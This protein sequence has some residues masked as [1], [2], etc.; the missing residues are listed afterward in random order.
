[1]S[2]VGGIE[3]ARMDLIGNSEY[4]PVIIENNMRLGNTAG[5]IAAQ[6]GLFYNDQM[7]G[8][9]TGPVIVRNNGGVGVRK[10]AG[11]TVIGLGNVTST[12]NALPDVIA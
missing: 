5:T 7:T 10:A 3:S 9:I 11:A 2:G 12:G 8:T 4:G 6:A 1:V